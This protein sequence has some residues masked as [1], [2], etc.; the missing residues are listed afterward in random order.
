MRCATTEPERMTEEEP[1]ALEEL[2]HR[3]RNDIDRWHGLGPWRRGPATG[4]RQRAARR[5]RGMADREPL[6]CRQGGRGGLGQGHRDWRFGVQPELCALS[7]FGGGVG[8]LGPRRA[9]S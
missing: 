7:W 9:V 4:G 3:K 1:H 6:S 5:G 8:R 2:E